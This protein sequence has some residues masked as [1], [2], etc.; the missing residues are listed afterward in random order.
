MRFLLCPSPKA[1]AHARRPRCSACLDRPKIFEYNKVVM[2]ITNNF[3]G[4]AACRS[5]VRLAWLR[6]RVGMGLDR[7]RNCLRCAAGCGGCPVCVV[8]CSLCAFKRNAGLFGCALSKIGVCARVPSH[9]T[10]ILSS[11]THNATRITHFAVC[12]LFV[13]LTAGAPKDKD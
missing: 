10:S 9:L 7:G 2:K 5:P 13:R 1:A 3:R 4:K 6:G 11:T 8:M 12:V